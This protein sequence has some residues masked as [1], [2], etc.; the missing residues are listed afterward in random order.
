MLMASACASA[1]QPG[2]DA[3]R[4]TDASANL[5]AEYNCQVMRCPEGTICEE[6]PLGQRIYRCRPLM[7][8]CTA[9]SSTACGSLTNHFVCD[10]PSCIAPLCDA[11]TCW[12]DSDPNRAALLHCW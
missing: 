10:C 4:L 6:P 2:S 5:E 11:G 3:V 12:I 9:P 1:T 7:A 8:G